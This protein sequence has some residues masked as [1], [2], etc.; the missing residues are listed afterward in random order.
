[1]SFIIS[2]IIAT[3]ASKSSDFT[4]VLVFLGLLAGGTYTISHKTIPNLLEF[5]KAN[6][7]FLPFVNDMSLTG[8]ILHNE[9]R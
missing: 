9:S 7:A 6:I 8:R 4:L 3:I 2:S 5:C 1:M